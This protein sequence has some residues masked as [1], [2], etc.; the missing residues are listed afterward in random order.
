MTA[1]AIVSYNLS[2]LESRENSKVSIGYN[3][4]GTDRSFLFRQ[5]SFNVPGL[6]P[7]V[8]VD[9]LD[10]SIFDQQNIDNGII[11]I[12]TTR[13]RAGGGLS[14]AQLFQP[15]TYDGSRTINAVFGSAVYDVTGKL[16]V[17]AGLRY[18]NV[19]Q[20]VTWDFNQDRRS[21]VVEGDN[22]TSF[23]ENYVLPSLNVKYSVND[24]N[25][26]RLSASKSYIL[27]QFKETAPFLYEDIDFSSFGNSVVNP[28]FE[29]QDVVALSPS[30]VYN[31]D[32]KWDH[33]F[34]RSELLSFGGFYKQ[35]NNAINRV[36]VQSAATELSYVNSGD[37]TVA[38]LEIEL[39]KN[40]RS[41]G[42]GST[43]DGGLNVS[44]LYSDQTLEDSPYDNLQTVFTN[45]SSK[46]EG[47]SPLLINADLTYKMETGKTNLTSSFIY[48]S[49]D[50]R[51]Y[52]IGTADRSNIE[53]LFVP[54]L[55]LVSK[56]EL[57]RK[58]SVGLRLNNILDPKIEKQAFNIFD[59]QGFIV[60]SYRRGMEISVGITYKCF[61]N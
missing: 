44:W 23:E 16:I 36:L 6:R 28:R 39:R 13:G 60:N 5:Y 3:L 20:E 25:I 40:V 27:P 37:V 18:E 45:S 48:S 58:L 43:L 21:P 33:F 56:L 26:L 49:F 35:I 59:G 8:D 55:D 46:L 29:G 41:F 57:N 4:R 12:V 52:S 31:L 19:K 50:A 24:D 2:E 17:G 42:D 10:G 54:T 38:G 61:N 11:E 32:V 14:N 51:P 34:N 7:E 47:A 30:D 9:D 1:K 22:L 53:E 15:D